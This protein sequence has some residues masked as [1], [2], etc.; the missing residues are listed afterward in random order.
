MGKYV[1]RAKAL[2]ADTA[3]HYNCA[4]AVLLAFQ[5]VTGLSEEQSLKVAA[6]FGGGLKHGDTCGAICGGLMVLGF[7]GKEDHPTVARLFDAIAG[8]NEGCTTCR[9]LVALNASKG[10]PKKPHCDGMVCMIAELIEK[11][12]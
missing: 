3:H 6:D 2:R 10:L 8:Q 12:M 11:M 9:E 5:D 7:L 1:E 4:Q